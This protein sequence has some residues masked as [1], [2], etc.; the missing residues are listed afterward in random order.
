MVLAATSHFGQALARA[1]SA[2]IYM[3]GKIRHSTPETASRA[4]WSDV[5][6]DVLGYRAMG[7]NGAGK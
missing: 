3:A 6:Y 4:Q 2:V 5:K 1:S 7:K